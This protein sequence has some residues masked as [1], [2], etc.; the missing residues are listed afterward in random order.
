MIMSKYRTRLP[1]LGGKLFLTD[2]GLET[3]LI[4]H[5]GIDLPCFASFDL[6]R[7]QDG[8]DRLRAYFE[9]YLAIAKAERM[10]FILDGPTWRASPDWGEKLGYSRD[11]LAAAN[12]ESVEMLLELR[13]RF[14]SP[15]S[16]IVV[17]GCM[18]PR[19]DGYDPGTLMTADQAQSYHAEQLG[20][21]A[22]AGVDMITSLTITNIPEAVGI[23]RAAQQADLP[24]VISFTL[25]TDGRLPTGDTLRAAIEAVDAETG[26]GP[27]YY[28]INCAHPTHFADMLAEGG[29]W[30]ERVRGLRANASKRS[31]AELDAAPDLDDGNPVELGGEYADLLRQHGHITVMGG[32]CGTDHRHVEAISRAC[33]HAA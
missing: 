21:L 26:S 10:G 23:V 24:V 8:K 5:D 25:E 6:M 19:G 22:D 3:T 2:G 12:R 1:Q 17:S 13:D 11:A 28:M 4:F 32:C 16:P 29:A 27:A 31:H 18:G 14:E 33:K 15:D 30:L 7:T 20:W 9:R